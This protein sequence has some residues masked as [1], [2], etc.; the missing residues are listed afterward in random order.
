MVWKEGGR[1]KEGLSEVYGRGDNSEEPAGQDS[2]GSFRDSG[3]ID[4]GATDVFGGGGVGIRRLH[5][6]HF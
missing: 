2:M 5:T 6:S 4:K 1:S 3:G